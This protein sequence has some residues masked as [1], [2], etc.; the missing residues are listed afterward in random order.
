M[1]FPKER[2]HIPKTGSVC[3]PMGTSYTF[4]VDRPESYFNRNLIHCMHPSVLWFYGLSGAGK[5]SLTQ[6][7]ATALKAKKVNCLV[8][9]GDDLRSGLSRDL[10]FSMNDRSE[11]IRRAAEVARLGCKQGFVVLVALITPTVELRHEAR[12]IIHPFPFREIFLDCDYPT[13]AQRDVKGLYARV[14]SGEILNFTGKDSVFE[15]PTSPDLIVNTQ[16][17]TFEQSLQQVM[18]FLL[19]GEQLSQT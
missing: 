16:N 18:N 13:A 6:A 4:P 17:Q 7:S 11:N 8:L 2:Q 9:D 3:L 15:A 10:Q 14:A 5:T 1:D 12:R 19:E